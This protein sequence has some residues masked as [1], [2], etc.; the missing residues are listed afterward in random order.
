VGYALLLARTL[1]L[2]RDYPPQI[3][4]YWERLEQRDG[5]RR[6]RAAQGTDGDFAA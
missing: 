3:A 1:R 2:D 6:A 5:Y 4:A